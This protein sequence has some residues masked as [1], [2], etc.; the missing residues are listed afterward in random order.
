MFGGFC[1]LRHLQCVRVVLETSA[2]QRHSSELARSEME[3]RRN[4]ET[5]YNVSEHPLRK[6]TKG[7]FLPS[8]RSA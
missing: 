7:S 4:G 8:Q 1:T 2:E 6:K 5:K 3:R